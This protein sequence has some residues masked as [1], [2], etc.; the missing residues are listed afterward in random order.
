MDGYIVWDKEDENSVFA[1]CSAIDLTIQQ[2]GDVN[3]Y[4]KDKALQYLINSNSE[5]IGLY[6]WLL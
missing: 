5:K 1:K 4:R 2:N 6:Y 3:D